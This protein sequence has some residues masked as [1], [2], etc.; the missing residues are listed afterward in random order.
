MKTILLT[1]LSFTLLNAASAQRNVDLKVSLLAPADGAEIHPMETFPVDIELTNVG[2][3]ALLASDSLAVYLIMNGDTI[4]QMSG[5]YWLHT[6]I[7]LASQQTYILHKMMAFDNSLLGAHID[8]CISVRPYNQADPVADN[9]LGNNKSCVGVD[10]ME[11]VNSLEEH[12]ENSVAVY[13]NPVKN[14]LHLEG[15]TV[16]GLHITDHAGKTVLEDPADLSSVDCS[17]LQG[18]IYF[19]RISTSKGEVVRKV[20][21]E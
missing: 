5:N 8:F 19:V 9:A 20:V 10:V 4:P 21:V 6:D 2:Q 13:P 12:A 14:I 11:P 1:I 7:A 15:E 3:E 16:T 18:G 17:G